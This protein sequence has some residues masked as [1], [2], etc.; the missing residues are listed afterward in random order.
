MTRGLF[1]NGRWREL[2]GRRPPSS[3]GLAQFNDQGDLEWSIDDLSILQSRADIY[4]VNVD[5]E[6]AWACPYTEFPIVQVDGGRITSWA[7]DVTGAEALL[8]EGHAV[9]LVGGYEVIRNQRVVMGE[10]TA[11][12]FDRTEILRLAMPDG[13]QFDKKA[14]VLGRGRSLVVVT[15]TGW[16]TLSIN[17]LIT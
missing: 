7:T 17:E 13:S 16:H 2:L 15:D 10:L 5:D 4:A 11:K 14:T 8:V 9:A 12:G 3:T 1:G 6:I